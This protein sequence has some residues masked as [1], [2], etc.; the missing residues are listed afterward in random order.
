MTASGGATLPVVSIAMGWQS[1]V[2][3]PIFATRLM[4]VIRKNLRSFLVF[5]ATLGMFLEA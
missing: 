1:L 4:A 5:R 2:I 3:Q